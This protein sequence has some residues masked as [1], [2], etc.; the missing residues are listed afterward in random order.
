M[1]FLKIIAKDFVN[2]KHIKNSKPRITYSKFINRNLKPQKITVLVKEGSTN[3]VL[4]TT[5]INFILLTSSFFSNHSQAFCFILSLKRIQ[6][7]N[8]HIEKKRNKQEK[9]L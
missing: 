2:I 8:T 3:N 1:F 4:S 7:K 9:V 5:A 6:V